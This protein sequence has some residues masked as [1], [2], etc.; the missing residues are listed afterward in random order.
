[1]SKPTPG[2]YRV[3]NFACGVHVRGNDDGT[4]VP[5]ASF[6][7]GDALLPANHERAEANARAWVEGRE[8]AATL[9][10]I[11]AITSEWLTVNECSDISALRR[12]VA[13]VDL[14]GGTG[15]ASP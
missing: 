4:D 10:K 15:K 13:I 2:P 7:N 11:R 9:E 3:N 14:T 6:W 8:A 12:I 1:M 5:I